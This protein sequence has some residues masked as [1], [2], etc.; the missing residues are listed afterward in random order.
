MAA[1]HPG[2]SG[3]DLGGPAHVQGAIEGH[4]DRYPEAARHRYVRGSSG[5]TGFARGG[6][7]SRASVE[8]FSLSAE[9]IVGQHKWRSW[10]SEQVAS[11]FLVAN[12]EDPILLPYSR[13]S[14]YWN[15]PT[16]PDGRFLHFAGTHRYST[17]EYRRHTERAIAALLH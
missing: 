10:G 2:G 16:G 5:F 7:P 12:S 15:E 4:W 11:N 17:S 9:G 6:R 3:V 1:Y 8:A 14:N 13:Y